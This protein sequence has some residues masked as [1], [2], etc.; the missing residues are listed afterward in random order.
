MDGLESMKIDYVLD[1]SQAPIDGDVYL[2]L[3]AVF[4]LDGEDKN[5]THF[6]KLNNN[7]YRT[8]QAA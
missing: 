7:L 4:H 1:F 6:I 2:H 5:E 3:P 8:R